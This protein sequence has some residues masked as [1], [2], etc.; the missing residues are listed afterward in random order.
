MSDLRRLLA[1]ALQSADLSSNPNEENAIDRVLALA[2][3]DRLGSL[4]WRLRWV[5]DAASFKPAS[6]VLAR[7]FQQSHRRGQPLSRDIVHRLADRVLVE[8]L[9]DVCRACMGRGHRVAKDAPIALHSCTV[10]NGT[11]RRRHSDADRATAMRFMVSSPTWAERFARAH[12]LVS[13]ADRRTWI[14]VAAQL[15]RIEGR[16]GFAKKILSH[17]ELDGILQ[18]VHEV[19]V[20]APRAEDAGASAP[21]IAG[22]QEKSVAHGDVRA[23]GLMPRPLRPCHAHTSRADEAEAVQ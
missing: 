22:R 3:A 23:G 2:T 18:P 8:W 20:A 19:S 17:A 21:G 1:V 4:L 16:P 15:E 5:N 13:S 14:E 6:L 7:R 9:D 10:C 11:G 12:S